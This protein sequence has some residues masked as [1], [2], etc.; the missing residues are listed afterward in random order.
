M[1]EIT[2]T[3]RPLTNHMLETLMDCYERELMDYEPRDA[4]TLPHSAGLIHRGM[5]GT[6][7]YITKTGKKIIVFYVTNSGRRYLSN[8]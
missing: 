7:T 5:L 6:R 2:I 1:I 8:L 4:G 3:D